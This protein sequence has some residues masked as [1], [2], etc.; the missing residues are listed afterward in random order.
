M[1][2]VFDRNKK[3]G[4]FEELVWDHF[5]NEDIDMMERGDVNTEFII[6]CTI[7]AIAAVAFFCGVA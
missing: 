4:F 6:I 7:I 5:Y 1:R 2:H 3:L